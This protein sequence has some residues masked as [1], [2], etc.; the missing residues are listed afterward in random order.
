VCVGLIE[1]IDIVLETLMKF[2][3]VWDVMLGNLEENVIS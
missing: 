3:V 2:T 1:N